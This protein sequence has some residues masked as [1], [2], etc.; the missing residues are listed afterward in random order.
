[1]IL[2]PMPGCW[3]TICMDVAAGLED[4]A[5]QGMKRFAGAEHYC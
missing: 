3:A 2:A 4:S 5:T 1:M